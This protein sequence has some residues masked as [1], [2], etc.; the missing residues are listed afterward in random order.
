MTVSKGDDQS[1]SSD[2]VAENR[3]DE[4]NISEFDKVSI[5]EI[6][7]DF[8]RQQKFVHEQDFLQRVQDIF[9]ENA[10]NLRA[11]ITSSYSAEDVI[12]N[13]FSI[14]TGIEAL[15]HHRFMWRLNQS[16]SILCSRLKLQVM[17]E[18]TLENVACLYAFKIL[19]SMI[20]LHFNTMVRVVSLLPSD[21]LNS[22][23]N[24]CCEGINW[25][26][27]WNGIKGRIADFPITDFKL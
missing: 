1:N 20:G 12:I 11:L 24:T 5:Y 27:V 4:E 22:D 16:S 9:H 25:T 2:K 17:H 14:A 21:I 18:D 23:G 7:D 26:I 15:D 8:L 3:L 13:M 10:T 19:K 6:A